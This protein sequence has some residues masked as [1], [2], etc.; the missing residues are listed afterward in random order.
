VRSVALAV[1]LAVVAS[2]NLRDPCFEQIEGGK[3]Y[4]VTVV[5][6]Y[7]EGGN[8]LRSSSCQ[9]RVGVLRSGV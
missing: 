6:P 8:F 2:C 1:V 3:T 7:V 4:R 5:E 9:I